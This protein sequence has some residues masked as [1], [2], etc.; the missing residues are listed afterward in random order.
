MLLLHGTDALLMREG[1]YCGEWFHGQCSPWEERNKIIFES[2]QSQEESRELI[3]VRMTHWLQ[4]ERDFVTSQGQLSWWIEKHYLG[5]E[6]RIASSIGLACQMGGSLLMSM[7]L[8]KET[9]DWG[10]GRILWKDK[11]E[12]LYSF[13]GLAGIIES[14]EWFWRLERCWE[15]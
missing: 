12:I 5:R 3:K 6:E 8:L 2:Q 4:Q 14:N 7:K 9:K 1:R 13:S 15:P 10:I 11:G